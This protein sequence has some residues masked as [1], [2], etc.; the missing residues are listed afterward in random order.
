LKQYDVDITIPESDLVRKYPYVRHWYSQ[1]GIKV[2][3]LGHVF[4][5]YGNMMPVCGKCLRLEENV[6]IK[7]DIPLEQGI[8][9][10]IGRPFE[11]FNAYDLYNRKANY[12]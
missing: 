3:A 8:E 6:S 10:A 11:L 4:Q 1:E 5:V 7:E 12:A 9:E 2:K